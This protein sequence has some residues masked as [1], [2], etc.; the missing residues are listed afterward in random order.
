MISDAPMIDAQELFTR[1][2]RYVG[3]DRLVPIT[4][5]DPDDTTVPPF[6][7]AKVTLKELVGYSGGQVNKIQIDV[8]VRMVQGSG[9]RRA[10]EEKMSSMRKKGRTITGAAEFRATQARVDRDPSGRFAGKAVE[11]SPRAWEIWLDEVTTGD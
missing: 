5:D 11:L 9:D 8:I 2:W 4:F 3:L 1:V 10:V 7:S 6:A